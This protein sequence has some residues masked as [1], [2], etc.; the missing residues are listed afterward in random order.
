[1]RVPK[2]VVDILSKKFSAEQVNLIA[3]NWYTYSQISL[4]NSSEFELI[5]QGHSIL[6]CLKNNS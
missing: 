6:S 4:T 3:D 5:L 2:F 1:M